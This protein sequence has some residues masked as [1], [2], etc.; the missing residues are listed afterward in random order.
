MATKLQQEGVLAKLASLKGLIQR[1][2]F[3]SLII[4]AFGLMMLGKADT[5]LIER[6]RTAIADVAAPILDALSRPAATV[7]DFI[8]QVQ[9]MTQLREENARLREEVSRLR[10]WHN[11]AT[12]LAVENQSLREM[13]NF[14]PPPRATF[15]SGRVIADGSGPFSRSVLLNVGSRN[16]V[17]KGQAV[18]ND[19]GLI[20]RVIEVGQRSTRVLLLTDFNS[21]VP[22][23]FESSRERAILAGDNTAVMRLDFVAPT[24]KVAIGERVVTSGH[25]G[26]LPAG[27]PVG[28]ISAVKDGVAR[29]QPFVDWSR[30]EYVRVVDYP[31]P[32]TPETDGAEDADDQAAPVVNAA[33]SNSTASNSTSGANAATP[34][35]PQAQERPQ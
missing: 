5:I 11:V 30:L 35:R 21:R 14:V 27:L 32:T 23:V 3:L 12:H 13:L 1:F 16:G 34:A 22:I 33:A 7:E 20:G 2:T 4:A 26:L 9:E 17:T 24:A 15:V 25:G 18:V 29:V 31:A 19:S 10:S 6:T 8:A 28:T